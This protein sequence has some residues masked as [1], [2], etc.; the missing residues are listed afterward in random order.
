[1][2]VFKRVVEKEWSLAEASRRLGISYRQTQRAFKRFKE[3][4]DQGLAH[5]SR[6]KPS[7]NRTDNAVK[8]AVLELYRTQYC[9]F[10][11]TLAAEMISER[12]GHDVNHETLRLWL[13]QA[14]LWKPARKRRSHH[15]PWRKR[16]NSFGELVQMD[17]SVHAWFEDRGETCF[18]MSMVDDATGV[19]RL[20]FSKEETT[21]A[22]MSLLED[23]IKAYGVPAALYVDRKT[24]YVTGR[25]PT[26]EEQLSGV[27]ALTQFGRACKK[28]G[29]RIIEAHS[30]QAKGRVERKHQ[31]CQ[32]RLIKQMRLAKISDMQAGAAFLPEWTQKINAKFAIAPA[33]AANLHQPLPADLD[34][35]SVFCLEET[36]SVGAEGVVR[37]ANRWYQIADRVGQRRPAQKTKVTVQLWRD[38]A[39]HIVH[40]RRELAV[41]ELAGPPLPA[42]K[43]PKPALPEMGKPADDHPW[44][45]ENPQVCELR[46]LKAEIDELAE[47][48]LGPVLSVAG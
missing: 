33:S 47:T 31:V 26:I 29:V 27:G 10:G 13:L 6:G 38:G 40:G 43:P 2:L 1:M 42:P 23:W 24:V 14:K 44:R 45:G 17:G 22:A 35:R 36:R 25:E 15:L 37:F 32:D 5:R 48:Y 3:E 4:G 34:L 18:L 16:K 46:Q 12:D 41:N 30:P 11:P 9:D 8:E 7:G 20:L 21:D 28:L 39:V 19:T